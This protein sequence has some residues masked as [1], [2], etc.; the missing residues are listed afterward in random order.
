MSN[1]LLAIT[2]NI[3]TGKSYVA[4]ILR[5][6]HAFAHVNADEIGHRVL[7]LPEVK[8]AL[9]DIFGAGIFA[10]DEVDR[11][12][13]GAQVFGDPR[14]L[15]LL[16]GITHPLI[17]ERAQGELTALLEAG[18]RVL[19]EAAVLFEAGWERHF[20]ATLLTVCHETEQV[21]RLI[22]RNLCN[23]DEALR[24]IRAQMPQDEKLDRATYVIDTTHGPRAF[25]KTLELIVKD[26]VG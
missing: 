5:R 3:A 21:E 4:E 13:L 11:R 9:R 17:I 2:G 20:P 23:A 12:K 24:I 18:H 26:I 10:D 16:N 6:D 25:R 1:R 14:K 19:F 7:R 22:R 8:T 15:E